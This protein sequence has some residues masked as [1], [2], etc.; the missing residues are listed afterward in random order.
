VTV[1]IFT[2]LLSKRKSRAINIPGITISPK[3]SIAKLFA[4][5]PCSRRSCGKTTET[6]NYDNP[7]KG[8]LQ[9]G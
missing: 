1:K 3:P 9:E 5:N 8:I 4:D 7:Y 2:Y 6:G